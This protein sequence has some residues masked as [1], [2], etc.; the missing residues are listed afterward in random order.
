MR[1]P[2]KRLLLLPDGSSMIPGKIRIRPSSYAWLGT[3]RHNT[4]SA[5]V[6][7]PGIR[8]CPNSASSR[9]GEALQAAKSARENAR[10]S[11]IKVVWS[12]LCHLTKGLMCFSNQLIDVGSVTK[13]EAAMK[14]I[15]IDPGNP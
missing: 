5:N 8:H 3:P 7:L 13:V 10:K 15:G 1:T 11:R 12:T 9:S 2:W 14:P 6:V 4:A